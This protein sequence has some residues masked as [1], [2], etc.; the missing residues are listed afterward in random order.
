M[1]ST[2]FLDDTASVDAQSKKAR[3]PG[4]GRGP[5]SKSNRRSPKAL[6]LLQFNINGISTSATRIKL[7]QVLDLAIMEGVQ[8]IALQ[9][10]KLKTNTSLKIKGFNIFR[11][12][13]QSGSGGGL[14]FLI[15]DVKYQSINI[16]RKITDGSNLEIQGI[17]II[18]RGKPLNIFNVYHPPDVKSLPNDLQDLFNAGTIC[19]GDLNAKHPIWGCSTANQRG[20]ELLDMIDDRSFTILNDG[21]PT[22]FSYSYNTK[23]ALDI[24][25][26]SSDLG[27][28]CGWTVL[29]NLGSDHLPV[30]I[31]LK[32]RQLVPT[33]KD[34]QWIFK[35]ADWQLFTEIID[36][37]IRRK[38]LS[39]CVEMNWS[40][41]RDIILTA[42]R[43][44]IPRGQLKNKKPYI[45]SKSPLLQPLLGER[46]RIFETRDTGN[47]KL[48]R[49]ELNKINAKIKRLYAQIK[50]DK[51]N[52]LCSSLDSRTSDGKLWKLVRNI[53]NE[54]PQEEQSNTIQNE[55]GELAENDEEAANL[56][57]LYYQ[58][59]SRL[60][61]TN[62]NKNVKIRASNIVHGCRSHIQSE[63]GIFSRDYRM[64]ELEAAI[65]DTNLNKSPGPDGIHGQ[66]I[67]KLSPIGR[68][69]LL[70]IINCSWNKG[71]LPRDWRRATVIPF[72][73]PGKT[74]G[75]PGNYR[76]IALT[77]I[78]C[79]IMEKMVLRRL[80]FHLH[81]Q[82]LLPEEQYGFREGHSTTDQL[83]YFCQKIRDAH[84]K[85]PTNH[86][87]AVFLDLSK[88][89]DR[90]WNNLLIIKLFKRFG[91]G[92]KALPWI[93]DFLRNRCFRVKYN[94]SLSGSFRIFQGVPQGSVLS[95]I[96]FSLYLSGIE[97]IIKLNC[98]VGA[99]ADDIVLWKSDSDLRRLERDINLVLEDIRDFSADHKL[100][101][102]PTKSAV[103]FFTTNRKLYNFQPN[104]LLNDQQLTVD[105]HPI[106]LGFV[107]DPE[108]LGNKHIDH[109]V[110]KAR[111]RLNILRYISGRDWG[112]DAGTLRNTYIT[113][114]RPILEYGIPIYCCASDTN[115]QKLEKVQLSA[116]RIITGLRNTCPRDIVLYE[117]D[118]QPL[119]LRRRTCLT[120][121]YSKLS[122]LGSQNRTSTY[123]KNWHFSQRLKRKSPFSKIVTFNLVD[124][125]VEPHHL[126][127]CLDPSDDLEGVFFHSDLSVHVNKQTDIPAYLKQVA[128]ER[129]GEIPNDATQ[130]YTDGSRDEYNRSGSG[131]YIK[132]SNYDLRIQRRNPDF[133]S[134]FRS[135]LIAI[136]VALDSLE[137]LPHGTEI[138]I[139]SDSKSAIQH[140]TS[141]Q[142]VRDN[143]GIS[144]LNKLKRL[145][146]SHYIH[147][148]WIP[149][150]VDLEGNEIADSLAKAG[151]ADV[152]VPSAPLTFLEIHS[153]IK[154]KNRT[155]WIVPPE[156]HWYRS[157]RPGGSLAVGFN[158]QEQTV[159]AR[160]RSGHLKSLKFSEGLKNFEICAKCSTE[161]AS[162]EHILVCLGLSEK[163]LT[164][165][166]LTVLDFLRVYGLM[167]LV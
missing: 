105:K 99:F 63:T 73:K 1:N 38:P 127:Q 106:Y 6:K 160:F 53:S 129:I 30:L 83:L 154:H 122:A 44:S 50:R 79:K 135:E 98:E 69:G 37:E 18:W 162:P 70:D 95:P 133:C 140:L 62:E 28:G 66:M 40:S 93:Y 32:K 54:Q 2:P 97:R 88:A 78:A 35:K 19:L 84:N 52:D 139:L 125:A 77:S 113:L 141:W 48:A 47:N 3:V 153:K 12:D 43:K 111:K 143:A 74:D 130:V 5:G 108:I 71:K 142:N 65:R 104:I 11:V 87:V 90:V 25:I 60:D 119:S 39:D 26:V 128:L 124:G 68:Q 147:L 164:E 80:T 152:C 46:K 9:E 167:D 36:N 81:S 31:E 92:G 89:F 155:T 59:I 114:I 121:Y 85:K 33:S 23:E 58:N 118:L 45:T 159:L 76:P 41:F 150:H 75:T 157:S 166:P 117:A 42:A 61:F 126:K 22:H 131:I 8:V 4:L 137:F 10:T 13:R 55:V 109:L 149:S 86:T 123:F 96:L 101:F 158:R 146:A 110:L 107:L 148:Q 165:N 67:D 20:N 72:K 120:K 29:E 57:G 116:A 51:W 156:H 136:D 132:S 145:S 64:S 7:D 163:D 14:A 144:I 102:N 16:N 100:C 17:R 34:K 24:S 21:S 112:T 103:S 115:L 15:R 138:W 161:Q 151:V 134:V 49:V 82:D 56:L 94:N 27:P 91:I